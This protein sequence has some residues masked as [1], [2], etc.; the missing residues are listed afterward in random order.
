VVAVDI[1]T[2]DLDAEVKRLEPG[3]T[4]NDNYARRWE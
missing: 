3:G 4:L 2:D 1:Y